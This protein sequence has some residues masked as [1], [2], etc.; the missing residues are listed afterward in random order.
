M[1]AR[2][3]HRAV[4]AGRITA[5]SATSN[6]ANI[7]ASTSRC[8]ER[9]MVPNIGLSVGG[10]QESV[11]AN[12]FAAALY[13]LRSPSQPLGRLGHSGD[14]RFCKTANLP[15][16]EPA[17]GTRIPNCAVETARGQLLRSP[18]TE[19]RRS[20]ERTAAG[21]RPRIFPLMTYPPKRLD[22]SR[23]RGRH[24]Q[25]RLSFADAKSGF[26]RYAPNLPFLLLTTP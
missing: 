9:I 18:S 16:A 25:G 11:G 12:R 7:T 19:G 23:S 8:G 10:E 26:Q 17:A 3:P 22:L 5:S 1:Q 4:Y 2:R 15:F 20:F 13:S 14:D 21:L 6:A 24:G